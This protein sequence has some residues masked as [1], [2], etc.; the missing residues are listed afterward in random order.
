MY[1]APLNSNAGNVLLFFHFTCTKPQC[2]VSGLNWSNSDKYSCQSVCDSPK[3][4]FIH[5][6]TASPF[7]AIVH[8]LMKWWRK[9]AIPLAATAPKPIHSPAWFLGERPEMSNIHLN[10][11]HQ[12]WSV[13]RNSLLTKHWNWPSLLQSRE[14]ALYPEKAVLPPLSLWFSK[15][16]IDNQEHSVC[17]YWLMSEFGQSSKESIVNCILGSKC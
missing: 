12:V 7:P 3:K 10:H 14:W 13:A 1:F 11:L 16:W 5:G 17:T 15:S 2:S 4:R 6:L 8:H 9:V